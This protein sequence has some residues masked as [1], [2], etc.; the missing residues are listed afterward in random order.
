MNTELSEIQDINKLNESLLLAKD[1]ITKDYL[2]QLNQYQVV[3][4][5]TELRELDITEYTR[6]YKFTKM[7]S[8]KKESVIDKFVTV[9]NAAYLSNATVVTFIKSNKEYTDYYLGVVNKHNNDIT[10]QG[11]TLKRALTGNFPGLEIL[12][13]SGN[14]KKQLIDNI[15]EYD[16]ITSISGI[17]S[18]RNEKDNS[19]EK[20]VQGIEHLI[21]SVAGREY[22]VVV[23]ADPISAKEITNTKLGYQSL[24]TQL[25]PFLKTS[26]SY[27]ESES[28]TV[29]KTHTDGVSESISES[30]SLTQSYSKTSGWN[31]G[32]SSG[33]STN[34]DTGN[35]LGAAGGAIIGGAAGF[36]VAG[37]IGVAGG[38]YLGSSIGGQI[39]SGLIGSQGTNTGQSSGTSGST[40]DSSGKSLS[41]SYSSSTQSSDS[42]G[43]SEGTTQGRTVQLS[44]ENKMV[45][46]LLSKIDKQ[47]ERLLKCE[48]YGAFNCA[49][50]VISSDPE[51]NAIVSSGYSALMRGDNSSLQIS[52]INN[53]NEDTRDR[54]VV[55]EYLKRLSHPLF[56]SPINSEILL[57]PASISNSYELTVNIGLPKKSINGLPVFE[58]AAFGRN[59]FETNLSNKNVSKINLGNI[60]HMG[61]EQS[62]KVD[63]NL[64]SLAM[65][66]FITGSTGSG[67]S[68]TVYQLLRELKKQKIHFLVIEPAKGEYKHVFGNNDAK[69]YGTNIYLTPLLKL[70]PFKFP[71]GIHVLEHIDRLIEIFNVCWPMYAAMP[72]V[73]KESVERSYKNAG[74]NLETSRNTYSDKLFPTF[75]DVLRELNN[76]MNE[77][78][79]SD[80]VRDNY[81][82]ALATRIQS[83]TNGI[84]KKIFDSDE[85]GD[86][87][88]FDE[89]VIVDL[90][91]VGSVETKSMIM[92]ILVMRL[93]EYR[94]TSGAMNA[95]LKHVTVLEEA[96]NLLKRTS[97]EQSGESSNLLGK[98]VEMLSNAIAEV[99]TYGEGFIIADQAPGLLDMSVIRNTNTKIIMRLPDAEDRNLVGKS[100]NLTEDQIKELAKIPT[101][102]AAVYQN[103]WLEP[104]LC[105]VG[106]E[107]SDGIYKNISE[108]LTFGYNENS[109]IINK[110]LDKVAG[111]KLDLN[112]NELLDKVIKSSFTTF[113]KTEMIRLFRQNGYIGID[114]I[115]SVIYDI[116]AKENLVREANESE[117]IEEWMNTYIY[118]E[119]S[120]V[121]NLP[122]WRKN[123]IA[124]CILREQIK[125]N[126][127]EDVYLEQF[128]E[129]INGEVI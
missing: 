48:S 7:V 101:G 35:L 28:I 11:E 77:S 85:L 93:Q 125:R 126:E 63:L 112:M 4:M 37:P 98:S 75:V 62:T 106:Y 80:E 102:I 38:A 111:E 128:R 64:K 74:W 29:S 103:N 73:L 45:K 56:I 70:N 67:K 127:V 97:T 23:I 79:F 71:E 113:E 104:V 88:L 17:A 47:V 117:S 105:K 49:T 46:D 115:Q 3:D 18:V 123:Q 81:I 87:K 16:Y 22:S 96:H 42:R 24:Y 51:T 91:R 53:W 110:L 122:E 6:I 20:F 99:R 66:T 129:F 100:A 1:I 43:E 68:N 32:T 10:T 19:Y 65:H 108:D 114:D 60:F 109:L 41:K 119:D 33:T 95:D 8:D 40:S 5:P 21:D 86:E 118:A 54:V 120:I 124:E 30:T 107:S 44:N 15:F 26:I 14:R 57:S 89:N 27:N 52:Q 121:S 82:G 39:G 83:L 31:E 61:A 59:V 78:A 12:P 90:S 84:Y 72:A 13:V 116:V 92:G 34:K 58:M 76:V 2:Y 94:M 9:L 55:K 69:V 25:S 50:Y 36:F